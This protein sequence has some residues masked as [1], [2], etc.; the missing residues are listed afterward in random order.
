MPTA[1]F[2]ADFAQLDAIRDFVGGAATQA[3]F[4]TK[5]VYS[6]QLATDEACSNV[7]EHAYKDIQGGDIEVTYNVKPGE[8]RIV[9]HDHG[10]EFDMGQVKKPNLSKHLEDREVGGLG[11]F[12]IHKLM[13]EVHFESTKKAGN[14]LTM[15]KRMSGG[16]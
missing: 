15:I 7:I 11:V 4:S 8:L 2:P 1:V 13:D 5:D 6:V 10:A 14:T 16:T 12:F 3:G 9:I